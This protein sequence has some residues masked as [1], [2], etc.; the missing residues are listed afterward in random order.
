MEHSQQIEQD[1]SY[2][3]WHPTVETRLSCSQCGKSMCTQ[4]LVQA[5][6]GIRCRECGKSEKMPTFDVQP[7]YYARAVGV[8]IAIALGGGLLWG[9]FNYIVGQIGIPFVSSF[10]ALAMGYG[11][12]ELI[13]VSVNRKRSK[14]LAW[15][16]GVSVAVAYLISVPANPASWDPFGLILVGV[17][18]YMAVVR[19]K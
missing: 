4:C 5:P 15:I 19:V 18:V 11:A 16:A 3:N 9:L 8:G 14:R 13:S 12:G 1:A 6:V 17:A 10:A 7:S 2:C